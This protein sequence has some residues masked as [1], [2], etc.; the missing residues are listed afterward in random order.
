M[1]LHFGVSNQTD[2]WNLYNNIILHS[3][4]PGLKSDFVT[5]YMASVLAAILFV[6]ID[7]SQTTIRII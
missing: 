4:I 3:V 7:V 2:P 1:S 6:L 5:S